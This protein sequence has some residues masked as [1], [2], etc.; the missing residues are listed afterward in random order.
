MSIVTHSFAGGAGCQCNCNPSRI[1][2]NS[3]YYYKL[4]LIKGYWANG[5]YGQAEA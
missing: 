2:T 4:N 5:D 3:V 1:E